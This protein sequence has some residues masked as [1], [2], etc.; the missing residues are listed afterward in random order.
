M[1]FFSWKTQDTD[2][3]IANNSSIRGTFSVTMIDDNG[4][5][6]IEHDYEGYG[7]FGGK[8][9]YEL[10]S[11][12]NGGPTSRTAG[13]NMA[14]GEKASELKYPN[15]VELADG[16][17][18]DPIGPENCEYQGF[19]YDDSEEEENSDWDNT[20]MDGL[21]EEENEF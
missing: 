16:W 13:I 3:S 17:K 2:R 12:M 19:F 15:L 9:Y 7:E 5:R 4:N 8:D 21:D 10:L 11:E 6:W 18:Y 1:G 14:F 20:L